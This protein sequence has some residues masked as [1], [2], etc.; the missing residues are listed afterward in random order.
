MWPEPGDRKYGM[1]KI[2]RK[3]GFF[4]GGGEACTYLIITKYDET[5]YEIAYSHIRFY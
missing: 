1:D 4:L 5:A 3:Y 2:A